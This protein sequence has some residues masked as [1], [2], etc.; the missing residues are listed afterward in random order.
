MLRLTVHLEDETE[1]PESLPFPTLTDR[2]VSPPPPGR[3]TAPYRRAE[4]AVRRVED[5]MHDAQL[6]FDR[7]RQMLGYD[8][9][10]DRP[11]AA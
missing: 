11:R 1:A 2:R 3:G 5:A 9:D 4:D 7:L 8:D 6:K 10:D